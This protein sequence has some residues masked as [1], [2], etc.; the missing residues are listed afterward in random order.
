MLYLIPVTLG[1]NNAAQ[2][3]PS[4]VIEKARNLEF[5]VVEDEKSARQFLG[6]I[7]STRPIRELTLTTLN[8]HTLDKELP[9]LLAP[10]LEGKDVGLM[11]E[12]GCPGIADP[13]AALVGLAHRKGIK[14]VPLVGPSSILLALIASGMNGQGFSFL[15]YLPSEKSARIQR[16]REIEKKSKLGG[17][18]QVFIETPYRNQHLLDDILNNCQPE[19]RLCIA[20]NITLGSEYIRTQRVADWKKSDIPDLNKQPTVFLLQG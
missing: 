13:G 1:D 7:K 3:L 14:V 16:I 17:E 4:Y 5:F 2:V 9:A 6:N 10:L 8:E 12:A 20:C 15:G 18:T 19:T 11:S